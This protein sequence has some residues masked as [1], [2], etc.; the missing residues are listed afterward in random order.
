MNEWRGEGG[1]GG[2][3]GGDEAKEKDTSGRDK[4]NNGN[5]GEVILLTVIPAKRRPAV[6]QTTPDCEMR[7]RKTRRTRA[8]CARRQE[9]KIVGKKEGEREGERKGKGER[10]ERDYG[11]ERK[12]RGGEEE[13]GDTVSRTP[14]E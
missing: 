4:S 10:R 5:F 14:R 7:K 6:P 9:R 2:G 1:M 8:V 13:R 12:S 11:G 3:E